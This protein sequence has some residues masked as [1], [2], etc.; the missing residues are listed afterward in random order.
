MRGI[1]AEFGEKITPDSV[2][3]KAGV[4]ITCS[5]VAQTRL[6]GIVSKLPTEF[7]E[8]DVLGLP[9]LLV[10]LETED[11]EGF[12]RSLAGCGKM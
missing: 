9:E 7:S 6:N 2:S 5:Y 4:G 3:T 12:L 10:W 8:E 1:D 11:M